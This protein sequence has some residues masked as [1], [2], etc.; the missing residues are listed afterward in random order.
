[1]YWVISNKLLAGAIPASAGLDGT[2]SKIGDLKSK[3]ISAIINLMETDER[4]KIGNPFFDYTP[5]ANELGIEVLRFPIKD[6]S[7]PT[8]ENMKAII[9]TINDLLARNKKVYIHCWGGI[10]RTGTVVGCFLIQQKIA[11]KTTVISLI[12]E[13]KQ[14]SIKLSERISPETEEQMSFVENW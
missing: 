4:D 9:S 13:L 1:M 10:G 5:I 3:D 7:I 14:H 2:K 12:N 6:V 11:T 8:K